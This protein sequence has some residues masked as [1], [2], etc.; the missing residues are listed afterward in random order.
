MFSGQG[1]IQETLPSHIRPFLF[2]AYTPKQ[3]Q[4]PV[5]LRTTPKKRAI[6]S[7]ASTAS[8]TGSTTSS[9]TRTKNSCVETEVM[10]W[11]PWVLKVFKKWY[12]YNSDVKYS[13]P[14]ALNAEA[15]SFHVTPLSRKQPSQEWWVS[16]NFLMLI[17]I[18]LQWFV[19]NRG[20][21]WP[22]QGTSAHI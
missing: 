14:G 4:T 16:K 6:A 10:A 21:F 2:R 5:M 13:L 9:G 1:L 11:G 17:S 7:P 19:L 22:P 12:V 8:T 3:A 18:P 20:Q 15:K